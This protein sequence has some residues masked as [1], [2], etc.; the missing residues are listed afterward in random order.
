VRDFDGSL[1]PGKSRLGNKLTRGV[2]RYLLGIKI[3]DTQTGLRAFPIEML[4]LLTQIEG[5]GFEY[6]TNMLLELR[7]A[8]L[9]IQELPIET[10]YIDSNATSHYR[11]LVDSMRIFSAVMKFMRF[12]LASVLAALIDNAIFFLLLQVISGGFFAIPLAFFIARA[13]SSVFNFFTN[14][15]AVFQSS[16]SLGGAAKRYFPLV[17]AQFLAGSALLNLIALSFGIQ[18]AQA[19]LIKV[20]VDLALFLLSFQ[21]QRKWVFGKW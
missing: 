2:F 5:S 17:L 8:G 21:I 7:N 18:A 4:P 11:P 1:T 20:V 13:V 9:N 16:G 10:V 14:H 3:S 19:T 6:E 15:K 12:S